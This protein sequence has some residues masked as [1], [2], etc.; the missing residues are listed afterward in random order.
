MGVRDDRMR[1]KRE[2][3]SYY[4]GELDERYINGVYNDKDKRYW[5]KISG[6]WVGKK[7]EVYVDRLLYWL[8][9]ENFNEKVIIE[10]FRGYFGSDKDVD[11]FFKYIDKVGWFIGELYNKVIINI[12]RDSI[13]YNR[14]GVYISQ[15]DVIRIL[16]VEYKFV[17][18]VLSKVGVV[19]EIEGNKS[20]YDSGKNLS[21][22]YLDLKV[23]GRRIG[24]KYIENKVLVGGIYKS[25][26]VIKGSIGEFELG[27]IKRLELNISKEKLDIIVQ[28]KLDNKIRE[29]ERKI[30]WGIDKKSK[31]E[32]WKEWLDGDKEEYKNLI[33]DRYESYRDNL[34]WIREGVILDNWF[35]IDNFSGRRY[36]LI[37][38]MDKEFRENLKLDGEEVVELDMRSC[39]VGCLVYF[40]ERFI[41]LNGGFYNGER[42]KVYI[43]YGGKEIF[44]DFLKNTLFSEE[45][46]DGGFKNY[47][48][49]LK[50][51]WKFR[52]DVW[53][54]FIGSN[55]NYNWGN[56][57][58]NDI[59][60][61]FG[62]LE[63]GD[64]DSEDLFSSICSEWYKVDKV[65]LKMEGESVGRVINENV[66]DFWRSDNYIKEILKKYNRD[67]ERGMW[68][69]SEEFLNFKKSVKVKM[70]EVRGSKRIVYK[71]GFDGYLVG[72][73]NSVKDIEEMIDDIYE[74]GR[75]VDFKNMFKGNI[76]WSNYDLKVHDL[77]MGK[78]DVV[79]S[80]DEVVNVV[81][82]MLFGERLSWDIDDD[83]QSWYRSIKFIRY[84]D[85]ILGIDKGV[86]NVR[87]KKLNERDEIRFV[88]ENREL[89]NE[90]NDKWN[91]YVDG[92]K[93]KDD[94]W[95]DLHGFFGNINEYEVDYE[96]SKNELLNV[97]W[98]YKEK[99]GKRVK[100]EIKNDII[101]DGFSS[102]EEF[103]GMEFLSKMELVFKKG[104]IGGL[105]FYD[106]KRISL[107]GFNKGG[108]VYNKEIY[109]DYGRGF[110]KVNV[111][112]MLF[113]SNRLEKYLRNFGGYENV[114]E[115]VFGKELW[116]FVRLMKEMDIISDEYG[117]KVNLYNRELG[118]QH[119]VVSKVLGL[120]EVDVMNYLK[121]RL[122]ENDREVIGI[123]DGLLMKKSDYWNM[124]FE[125]NGI[126][127]NEVGYM[128][129][130]K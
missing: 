27:L 57:K 17:L 12:R 24:K 6:K 129:E 121:N 47:G 55:R 122:Y 45:N 105:D 14:E 125:C 97:Y 86:Y 38:G 119:K 107:F 3:V 130:M 30:K 60:L 46:L 127:K 7:N 2:N 93:E 36:N 1:K 114:G 33:K 53:Y 99:Y 112:K 26:S 49:D 66:K 15:R 51:Y 128:F 78:S 58:G 8:E 73:L 75:L 92:L 117:D 90:I 87:G 68:N 79:E 96:G 108:G 25:M 39:Y 106:F 40:V 22:Y 81:N 59:D 31:I 116:K 102:K 29:V 11:G 100:Y 103:S 76:K 70:T 64:I 71:E 61:L 62:G 85:F 63:Y 115:S 34:N 20:K 13:R 16:G 72:K 104:D 120:I 5:N 111:M 65:R 98:N 126:L 18:D 41:R 37:N 101:V 42:R 23:L 56:V 113:S 118:K 80:R 67:V 69:R 123:F 35:G 9:F 52:K 10:W 84:V 21:N 54:E 89:Y 50:T 32:D 94:E 4:S 82:R 74:N 95:Y 88:I 43:E 124:R 48:N 83:S 28:G 110:W 19:I 44:K 109:G 77:L 91:I